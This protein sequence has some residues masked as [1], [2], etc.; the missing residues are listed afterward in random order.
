MYGEQFD[1]GTA[2]HHRARY[3]RRGLDPTAKALVRELVPL[4]IAG[5]RVLDIGGGVGELCFA[6][7]EAGAA[8][9]VNVELSPSW[10]E[11]A[12]HL[13]SELGWKDRYTH[14]VGDL[15]DLSPAP[16][17]ADLVVMHR[18]V[19][20][21]P[22]AN[23]LIEAAAGRSTRTLA[24]TFPT[25]HLLSRLVISFENWLRRR[26]GSQFRT[27]AHPE[28]LIMDAAERA[29]FEPVH[30]RRRPVWSTVIWRRRSTG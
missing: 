13:A 28:E 3:L 6:L 2:R 9:A 25:D 4:G 18:V 14:R 5:A 12:G 27:F 15:V 21:Y 30:R 7:L 22:D 29:G 20:C 23:R 17:D 24:A 11:T 8:E 19:C 26:R 10:T 16:D 1:A